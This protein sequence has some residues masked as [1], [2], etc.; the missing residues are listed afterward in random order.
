VF[1]NSLV[2]LSEII[3][4][5]FLNIWKVVVLSKDFV[6]KLIGNKAVKIGII[7]V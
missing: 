6:N 7:G 5:K 2:L 1:T 3:R 4:D